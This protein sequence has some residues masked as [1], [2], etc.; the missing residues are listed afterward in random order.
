M[1]RL[2]AMDDM[3]Q[4]MKAEECEIPI[5][6]EHFIMNMQ[7]LKATNAFPMEKMSDAANAQKRAKKTPEY[8]E[9]H[10]NLYNDRGLCFPPDR[11]QAAFKDLAPYVSE[12]AFQVV[13]YCA[14]SF[15]E[16]LSKFSFIDANLSL[17][18]LL[19]PTKAFKDGEFF[20]KN[21]WQT[22]PP[23]FVGSS[24]IVIR[25][26]VKALITAKENESRSH[27]FVY[28]VLTGLEMMSM[29]GWDVTPW[30]EDPER[31][32]RH[33]LLANLAGNAFNCYALGPVLL[34]MLA[35]YGLHAAHAPASSSRITLDDL[36]P[37]LDV[38]ESDD[39]S[40]SSA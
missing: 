34:A 37:L 15:P 38:E 32:P 5:H 28:R 6:A 29:I 35:S 39:D 1:F 31:M 33:E 8:V 2:D 4:A 13:Y 9:E 7:L 11:Q 17:S 10:I 16:T 20:L 25:E 18:F 26:K 14:E 36:N 40:S 27:C 22:K 3:L 19:K 21:P 30:L 24:L 23:C 12:R